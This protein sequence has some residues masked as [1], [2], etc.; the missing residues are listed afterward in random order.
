M[1]TLGFCGAANSGKTTI[2][3][4]IIPLLTGAGLKVAA[5]KHHG[6]ASPIVEPAALAGK[7]SAALAEAGC[8]RVALAHAGGVSLAAEPALA[9]AGPQAIAQAFMQGMDLVLVEGYKQESIPKLEVMAAGK[10][11]VL[12]PEMVLA[13]VTP[14][15]SGWLGGRPL[16]DADRPQVV[17]DFILDFLHKGRR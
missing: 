16:L 4:G 15:R 10:T 12:P 1:V 5:I 8:A 6:H 17:A 11:P 14:G 3:C 9:E 2:L 13:Y 7:D